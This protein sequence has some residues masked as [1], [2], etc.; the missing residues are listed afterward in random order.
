MKLFFL[1]GSPF[2]RIVRVLAR[3]HAIDLLE[4]EIDEFP[5]PE[6]FLDINPL[7]QVPVLTDGPEVHFPT[8]V[9]V[10]ALLSR[11][12]EANRDVAVTIARPCRRTEDEQNLAVILAMG[13]ALAAHHYAKWAGIGP[14]EFN[15]LG[16]DPAERNMVRVLRTLD[17]LGARM[18][19]GC[20]QPGLI[21]VQDIALT[22]FILW[23]ET[24][25]PI[26]WRGRPQIEMLVR[27]LEGRHSFLATAPR[28]HQLKEEP[29]PR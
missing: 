8:R 1:D 19:E 27:K 10:D 12:V 17:W 11:I 29:V 21:S 2:A 4:I 6:S 20:F 7:G 23:T 25:G 28:P 24:R 26:A 22:C 9:V 16:F 18:E 3:E 14:I 15:R 13:D 5:L